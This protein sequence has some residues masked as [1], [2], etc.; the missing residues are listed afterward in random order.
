M[1]GPSCAVEGADSWNYGEFAERAPGKSMTESAG[2]P[3]CEVE[4]FLRCGGGVLLVAVFMVGF[5]GRCADGAVL[6]WGVGASPGRSALRGGHVRCKH[7]RKGDPGLLLRQLRVSNTSSRS[8]K[9]VSQSALLEGVRETRVLWS[10][11][12]RCRCSLESCLDA[13]RRTT[14][15]ATMKI[16]SY[17]ATTFTV[18]FETRMPKRSFS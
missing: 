2:L 11:E 9:R 17:G 15:S 14:H 18:V 3:G 12:L 6:G 16:A 8:S 10:F 4:T 13:N 1:S 7:V 5:V